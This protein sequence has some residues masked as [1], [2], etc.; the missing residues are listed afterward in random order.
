MVKNKRPKFDNKMIEVHHMYNALDYPQLADKA[1]NIYPMT[2]DE[3]LYR[4]HGGSFQKIRPKAS[5]STH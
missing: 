1:F 2:R 3:H 5:H 4:W